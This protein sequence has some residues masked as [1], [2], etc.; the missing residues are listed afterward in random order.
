M[1]STA[2]EGCS[3]PASTAQRESR[4]QPT[5][6]RH[7]IKAIDIEGIKLTPITQ[8]TTGLAVQPRSILALLVYHY[9]RGVLASHDIES[10]LQSDARLTLLC[11]D[12]L[13]DWRQLRR[14]R[15]LNHG[16]VSNCLA[17]VLAEEH[18][19]AAKRASALGEAKQRL[20]EAAI[21]DELFADE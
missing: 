9:A 14:F 12:E 20:S 10:T 17:H 13:P 4:L 11:R 2:S 16:I 21:L 18:G 6:V 3:E 19:L 7:V 8:S 1:N 15:R 5:I